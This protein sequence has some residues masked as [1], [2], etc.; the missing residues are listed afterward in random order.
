MCS[1]LISATD[2]QTFPDFPFVNAYMDDLLTYSANVELR[3]NNLQEVFLSF[4]EGWPYITI[5]QMLHS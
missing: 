4:M 2:G 3:V 1:W 5:A